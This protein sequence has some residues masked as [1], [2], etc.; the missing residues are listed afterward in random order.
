[1]ARL[2]LIVLLTALPLTGCASTPATTPAA[3]MAV[4][5]GKTINADVERLGYV[6]PR[7]FGMS[8]AYAQCVDTAGLTA[9]V[10][11]GCASDEWDIQQARLAKVEADLLALADAYAHFSAADLILSSEQLKRSQD[12][13]LKFV[14][15][16]CGLRARRLGSTWGPAMSSE[17]EAVATAYRSQQLEDL[18]LTAG[19]ELRRSY[20]SPGEGGQK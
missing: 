12:L 2:P 7:Y 4:I 19:R 20:G 3:P 11:Q 8:E 15:E 1:M 5:D 13:W 18:L 14:L 17:C 10:M 9:S 6:D 16:D